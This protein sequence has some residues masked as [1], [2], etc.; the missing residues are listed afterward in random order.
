[1]ESPEYYIRAY[2]VDKV[3]LWL[4]N[5][6]N[7]QPEIHEEIVKAIEDE[8]SRDNASRYSFKNRPN[9]LH[10]IVGYA[11]TEYLERMIDEECAGMLHDIFTDILDF[12]DSEQVSMFG[13]RWMPDI[14]DI[15]WP[16][17]SEE[18]DDETE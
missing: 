6:E 2:I 13:D 5:D 11:V 16:E 10:M 12:G 15:T 9:E 18:S 1:M 3:S 4:Q 7:A 17:D 8:A 14:D